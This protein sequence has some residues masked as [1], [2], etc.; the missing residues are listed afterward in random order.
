MNSQLIEHANAQS[1]DAKDVKIGDTI[2]FHDT[3]FNFTVEDAYETTIGEIRF[4]YSN[5]TAS[6][7]YRPDDRLSVIRPTR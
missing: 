5:Y 1:M 2:V 6:S 7:C 4:A 3:R